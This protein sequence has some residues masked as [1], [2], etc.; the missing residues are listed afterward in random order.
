MSARVRT[1]TTKGGGKVDCKPF[2]GP[3][4]QGMV[5]VFITDK[6]GGA[7]HYMLAEDAITNH[8]KKEGWVKQ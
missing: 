1:F 2:E 4:M 5:S 8:A 6:K 7:T 3:R